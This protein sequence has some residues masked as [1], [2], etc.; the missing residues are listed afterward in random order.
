MSTIENIVCI[1][2]DIQYKIKVN[3][4]QT[5]QFSR[6]KA[7]DALYER[8][9]DLTDKFIEVYLG[10]YNIK[11]NF[12]KSNSINITNV[13][14]TYIIKYLKNFRLILLSLSSTLKESTELLNI[15]DEMIAEINQ[16]LYLFTLS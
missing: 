12:T 6:H 1:F 4:L 7:T 2:F 3:H 15:R 9:L 8:L 10:H 5:T 16:T 13:D 11:L 14:D